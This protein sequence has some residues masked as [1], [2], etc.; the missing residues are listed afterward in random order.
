M[1]VETIYVCTQEFYCLKKIFVI[2]SDIFILVFIQ[3]TTTPHF[4]QKFHSGRLCFVFSCCDP[5]FTPR[6]MSC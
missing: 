2:F 3:T 4:P 6:F 5:N 1:H